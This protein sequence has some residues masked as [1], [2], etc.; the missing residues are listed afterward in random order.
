MTSVRVLCAECDWLNPEFVYIAVVEER[1]DV[2]RVRGLLCY[3]E[4]LLKPTTG[5]DP[6]HRC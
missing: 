4:L 3:R 1:E 6:S 5:P 2:Q